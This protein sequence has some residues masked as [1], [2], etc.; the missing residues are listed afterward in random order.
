MQHHSTT[1]QE[2][3]TPTALVLT[4]VTREEST[5]AAESFHLHVASRTHKTHT[6]KPHHP[7]RRYTLD[8]NGG[9]YEGL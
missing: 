2:G 6:Y 5:P 3:A 4:V 8:D 9:S 7:A 1:R